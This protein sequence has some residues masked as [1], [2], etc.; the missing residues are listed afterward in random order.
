MQEARELGLGELAE[1]Y[2]AADADS[3]SARA[4]PEVLHDANAAP[5]RRTAAADDEIC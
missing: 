4:G 2:S 1:A 3:F 5:G